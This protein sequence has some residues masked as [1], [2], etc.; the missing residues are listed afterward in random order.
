MAGAVGVEP[1][2]S[3]SKP[4]AV[5]VALRPNVGGCKFPNSCELAEQKLSRRSLPHKKERK[6]NNNKTTSPSLFLV[7]KVGVEP[8]RPSG[9]GIFL[10]HYVTIAII[11]CCSL[12]YFFSISYDLGGRY[13]VSTHLRF[14]IDLARRCPVRGIRRISRHSLR[15]FLFLVLHL[16]SLIMFTRALS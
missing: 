12:D 9:Q 4:D 15:R 1:T 13:I 8:T 6:N 14:K 5:T 10:L 3:G 7:P 11:R 16:Y 2:S